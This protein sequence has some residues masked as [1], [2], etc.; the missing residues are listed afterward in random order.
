MQL[1]TKETYILQGLLL[2]ELGNE[3]SLLKGNTL[4][5]KKCWKPGSK[6]HNK[7]YWTLMVALSKGGMKQKKITKRKHSKHQ[8]L[9]YCK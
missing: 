9:Q 3:T 1:V 7:H 2:S 8:K 6:G 5:V 4:R